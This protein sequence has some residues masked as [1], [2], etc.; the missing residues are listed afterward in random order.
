MTGN[1][2]TDRLGPYDFAATPGSTFDLVEKM[3][4]GSQAIKRDIVL[5]ASLSCG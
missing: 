1:P 5:V 2:K 4:A 3:K